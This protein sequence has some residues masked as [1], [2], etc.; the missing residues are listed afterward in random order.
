MTPRKGKLKPIFHCKIGS[1][2]VPNAN[3]M[4]TNKNEM[5]MPNAKILRWGPNATYIPLVCV[6]RWGNAN[7]TFRVGGNANFSVFG[8]Q[9]VGI[10]NAKLWRWGSK[11]TPGP[12][13]NGFVLQWNIGLS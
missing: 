2:W 5:Y 3:E 1:L 6:M 13:A 10:P 4:S 11:P 8:Y 7:F 9:H 12:N